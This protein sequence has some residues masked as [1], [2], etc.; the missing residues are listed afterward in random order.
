M[1]FRERSTADPPP[2]DLGW[3]QRL[4][5]HL[6]AHY[7][8]SPTALSS[9]RDEIDI[10]MFVCGLRDDPRKEWFHESV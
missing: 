5:V 8:G 6:R 1:S 9:L 2:M 3:L 7:A 4:D 10:A